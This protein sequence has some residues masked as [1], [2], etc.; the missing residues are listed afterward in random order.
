MKGVI[1]LPLAILIISLAG[2]AGVAGISVAISK[3][4]AVLPDNP[5]LWALKGFGRALRC[6]FI[7]NTTEKAICRARMLEELKEDIETFKAKYKGREEMINKTVELLEKHVEKEEVE[8]EKELR[9]VNVTIEVVKEIHEREYG[10]KA[11]EVK[12]I[13]ERARGYGRAELPIRR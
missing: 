8:I 10:K 5:A 1:A 3:N 2:T 4:P 12:R 7:V 11:E 13:I 9:N 6:A